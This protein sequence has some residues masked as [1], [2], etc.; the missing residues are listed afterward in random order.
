MDEFIYKYSRNMVVDMYNRELFNGFV[1][2]DWGFFVLFEVFFF[3][4]LLN[5][6]ELFFFVVCN[7][8]IVKVK[9]EGDIKF[10]LR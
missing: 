9:G 3:F 4:K 10:F 5:L 8:K 7:M 2:W 6:K 1:W